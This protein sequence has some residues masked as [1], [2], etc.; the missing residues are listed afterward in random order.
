MNEEMYYYVGVRTRFGM[1]FVTKIGDSLTTR[2]L[3]SESPLAMKKS[4]AEVIAELLLANHYDAVVVSSYYEIRSH[5]I[6]GVDEAYHE[7][8]EDDINR[9]R[10]EYPK[11]T[12]VYLIE[13]ILGE[14]LKAGDK[15]T[16]YGVDDIGD[17]LVNWDNGSHINLIPEADKFDK[18]VV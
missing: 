4:K 12:R 16:V 13:D 9:L 2:W 10:K 6:A 3:L 14:D 8:T 11:G 17:I 15:G 1:N 5:F 18:L 7:I